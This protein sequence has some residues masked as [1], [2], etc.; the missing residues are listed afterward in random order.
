MP[1][2]RIGMSIDA[3]LNERWNK[4]AKKHKMTKSGMVEEYL[5]TI[6]PILEQETPN[7]MMAKAMKRMA[8]EIDTTGDLFENS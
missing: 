2:K 6:L 8:Q 3:E 5:E 7:K 4:V 1:Q